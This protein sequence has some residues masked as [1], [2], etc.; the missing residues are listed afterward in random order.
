MSRIRSQ[1]KDMKIFKEIFV[2]NEDHLEK[3]FKEEFSILL[4]PFTF[5]LCAW[6][7]QVILQSFKKMQ[8]G[9]I[10]LYADSGCHL[11]KYGLTRFFEYCDLAMNNKLPILATVFGEEMHEFMWTKADTF[12]YFNCS[13]HKEITHTP[14]IQATALLIVKT[15]ETQYFLE[16]WLKV[17][18]ERPDL[19][20]RGKYIYP[21]FEG[22][23]DHRSDQSFFSILG[24][25][26]GIKLIS[27]DEVQGSAKWETEMI[28]F[29]IWAMRDKE[30]SQP[31]F[32]FSYLNRLLINIKIRIK[33]FTT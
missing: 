19:A 8:C 17:F 4:K 16:K 5:Y 24:K 6:K 9:D 1:A 28:D 30:F 10:L 14:Q 18:R 12:Y 25:K 26:F 7:P 27:A 2:W 13:D 11:N 33:R 15:T 23:I 20:D 32:L 21:N 22:F 29:P 31:S 3:N